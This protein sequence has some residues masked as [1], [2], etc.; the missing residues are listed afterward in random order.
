MTPC[1]TL[2]LKLQA[3]LRSD[4]LGSDLKVGDPLRIGDHDRVL[5]EHLVGRD[6][7]ESAPT[8]TGG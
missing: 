4:L 8:V 5:A 6:P 3:R 7:H 1:S 2:Q